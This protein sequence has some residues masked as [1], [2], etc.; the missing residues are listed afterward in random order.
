MPFARCSSHRARHRLFRALRRIPNAYWSPQRPC[1]HGIYEITD[2]ERETVKGVKGVT[3]IR[4]DT[5][6][7]MR[8]W[9]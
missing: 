9:E 1:L 8:C 7:L 3:V 6:D 2:A 4:G 5:S